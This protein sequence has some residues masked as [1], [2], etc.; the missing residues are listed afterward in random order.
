MNIHSPGYLP[1]EGVSCRTK[2]SPEGWEQNSSLTHD[3]GDHEA[4]RL[5]DNIQDKTKLSLRR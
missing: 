4:W 1:Q 2:D 5:R 3:H